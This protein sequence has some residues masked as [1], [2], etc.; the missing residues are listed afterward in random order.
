[1]RTTAEQAADNASA[2]RMALRQPMESRHRLR[3]AGVESTSSEE[4]E[5]LSPPSN[6]TQNSEAE[7]PGRVIDKA[8]TAPSV[9]GPPVATLS[10]SPQGTGSD[11]TG[12]AQAVKGP[13][14]ATPSDRPLERVSNGAG[15]ATNPQGP[16]VMT[17]PPRVDPQAPQ[18]EPCQG[19]VK[20]IPQGYLRKEE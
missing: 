1:M 19:I 9:Q 2:R 17:P 5:E 20:K 16:S 18:P 4:D 15:T 3:P 11:R 8:G 10:D 13:P 7:T 12:T 6:A 14:V